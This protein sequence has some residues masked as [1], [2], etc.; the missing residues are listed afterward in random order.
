MK[1]ELPVILFT[2]GALFEREASAAKAKSEAELNAR[3]DRDR[4]PSRVRTSR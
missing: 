2:L 3:G 1:N 4:L